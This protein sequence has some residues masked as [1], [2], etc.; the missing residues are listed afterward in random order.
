MAVEGGDVVWSWKGD[1]KKLQAAGAAA[2]KGVTANMGQITKATG[3]AMTAAGAAVVGFAA[4]SVTNYAK[5]GDQI[6]KMSAKTGMSVL[7]LSQLKFAAEQSGA[8]IENI[9]KGM[10]NMANV[11]FEAGEGTATYTDLLAALGLTVDDFKGKSPDQAFELMSN[12]IRGVEDPMERAAIASQV[13]GK[14]GVELLP[15][16]N[17]SAEGMQ[18]LRD[19]ADKLGISFVSAADAVEFTDK[20]NALKQAFFGI[21]ITLAQALLPTINAMMPVITNLIVKIRE[22]VQA[23]PGLSTAFATV[24]TALGALM[25]AVGP[26]LVMLPG[27][28]A[29]WPALAGALGVAGA[30]L[31]VLT[32]P[33]GIVIGIIAALGAAAWYFVDDWGAVW[34]TVTAATSAAVQFMVGLFQPVFDILG[35]IIEAA[36]KVGSAIGGFIGGAIFGDGVEAPPAFASGGTMHKS[37]MAIVGEEGPEAV[38]LNRGST[39]VNNNETKQMIG[40]GGGMNI[41]LTG[42]VHIDSPENVR[43][44]SALLASELTTRMRLSGVS[45]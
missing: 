8:S 10:K 36:G 44:M 17:T 20:L 11:L 18:A 45:L 35:W 4:L 24:G 5:V 15:M 22:W 16:I 25:V 33:V 3:V 12:A 34:D 30:A 28:I 7:N 13:F 31:A 9:G 42:D 37:G 21:M 39:V 23:H 1:I 2:R 40:S 32:G 38:F 19:E 29:A 41:T 14:A 27:L 43:K 26:L 6:E